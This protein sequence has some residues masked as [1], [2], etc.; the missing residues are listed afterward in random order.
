MCCG[1][2]VLACGVGLWR[3]A[4]GALVRGSHKL[5]LLLL[6]RLLLLLLHP[7]LRLMVYLP[8]RHSG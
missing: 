8:Q 3:G 7:R 1:V 5:P 2:C 4:R 6:L